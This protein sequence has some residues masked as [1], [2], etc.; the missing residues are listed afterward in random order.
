MIF[1]VEKDIAKLETTKK[2]LL[3]DKV[4]ILKHN[5][6]LI[7]KFIQQLS[8]EG[9]TKARQKKYI[10]YLIR[11]AEM[12]KK[13]FQI[14]DK[15]DI[16]QVLDSIENA[17]VKNG[18]R[19]GKPLSEWAKHDLKVTLKRFYRWLR[20]TEGQE[21]GK[22]EYPSEVKWFSV[23]MKR[24]RKKLPKDML[25]VCDVEKLLNAA[26]NTRDKLFIRL[27]FESGCR[28]GEIL[29]LKLNCI[30]SDQYGCKI[31]VSGKTGERKLRVI[32]SEPLL[33][34]W[35]REHPTKE[36]T[37]SFLFC[38]LKGQPM[39]YDY[40]R[41][42]MHKLAKKTG[43]T[44]PVNCHHFRHSAATR[45]ANHLTE[46]QLCEYLGWVQGSQEAST[47]VHLSGRDVDNAI[48]RIHG[49]MKPEKED[50]TR[51]RII[52]PRCKT[53]ND[54]LIDLCVCCGMAIDLSN[55]M[56]FDQEKELQ[57]SLG[58]TTLENLT[59]QLEKLIGDAVHQQIQQLLHQQKK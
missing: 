53:V 36:N 9:I 56:K 46:A 28:V 48:L 19:K 26:N 44:K 13:E 55:I 7:L 50:E 11:I 33:I 35:M 25:K 57:A 47:Y 58:A 18:G 14:A 4:K 51:E 12:L 32:D 59:P 24:E 2:Y 42:L 40:Y 21:F 10:F 5:K 1:M 29:S 23:S 34:A 43:L 49:K 16:I 8:A 41:L 15:N 31:H 17:M 45:L 37:N 38:G 39:E 27:I 52:C 30:E 54:P 3:S 22:G 20:E 6:E